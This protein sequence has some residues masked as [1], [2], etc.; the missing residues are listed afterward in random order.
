MRFSTRSLCLLH[1]LSSSLFSEFVRNDA[2]IAS[3]NYP[4]I[5]AALPYLIFLVL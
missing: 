2:G 1:A 5:S 3:V 4:M